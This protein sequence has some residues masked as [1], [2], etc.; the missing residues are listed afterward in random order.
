MN[1]YV[2]FGSRQLELDQTDLGLFDARRATSTG[3]D[4]LVE[5][6]TFDKLSVFYCATDFLYDPYVTEVDV[7]GV[8][9]DET[10][11]S[12]YSNGGENGRVL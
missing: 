2:G 12:R 3:N 11:Y 8:L 4:I 6:D 10:S 1:I 9:V 5:D 7:G